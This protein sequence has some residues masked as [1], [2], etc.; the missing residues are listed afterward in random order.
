MGISTPIF[1]NDSL[2][3]YYKKLCGLINVYMDFRFGTVWEKSR[4]QKVHFRLQLH[5][6]MLIWRKS[7]QETHCWKIIQ[8]I[9]LTLTNYTSQMLCFLHSYYYWSKLNS[10]RGL[11]GIFAKLPQRNDSIIALWESVHSS[12]CLFVREIS[13]LNFFFQITGMHRHF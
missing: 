9:E 13:V 3:A 2:C 1:V 7:L 10:Q 5:I 6:K 8:R 4:C 11:W 12:L